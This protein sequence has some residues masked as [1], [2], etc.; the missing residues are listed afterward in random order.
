MAI[1]ILKRF[2]T[3]LN[4][5]LYFAIFG[6]PLWMLLGWYLTPK[7]KLVVA[8]VDKTVL[9]TEG[10][11]HISLTWVLN[12]E[13]FSKNN[14]E[15]YKRERDYYGFFPL[16]NEKYRLKGL[17]RFSDAQLEQLSNDIDL[18]YVTDAYG[19]FRNEWYRQGD[20][21]ER[22]GTVYGGLSEE[23][24]TLLKKMKQKKKLIITEFNC[25]ASPT[26]ETIRNDYENTFG[27]HWTG[28][29]GRY[30][31]SFDTLINKEIPKWL[32]ANYKKQHNNTWPFKKSGVAMIRSD[33]RVIILEKDTHL[34]N[35]LPHIYST[36]EGTGH[37][38]LPKKMKYSF[39]FD[40]IEADTTRNH[41][42][43][44]YELDVNDKGREI[45]LKYGLSPNFPAITVHNGSDYKF[46]YF[47]GD[48]SDNPVELTSS[49]FKQVK[50]F[51]WFMYN[52]RDPQ[53]RKSF[54]W[55]LYRPLVSTILNDHYETLR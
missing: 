17:E 32:V 10:Q 26:T 9:N 46:Y 7:R 35:D 34:D 3:Y 29:I 49:Y 23:D 47:S 27:V 24:F 40:V 45:L 16:D 51:K 22:S 38:G 36:E 30:F 48:F 8:I 14:S 4:R 21:K 53:E 33:D 52:A 28:W 6:L 13:K 12:Q 31:D 11:E 18:M 54:F 5:L 43:A 39:W 1:P 50:Y 15:L 20:A 19:I 2:R 44:S 37:Y 25:L 41:I 42:M 55:K